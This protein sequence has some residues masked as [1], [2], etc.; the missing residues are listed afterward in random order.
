MNLTRCFG[1]IGTVLDNASLYL[2][3]FGVETSA[4]FVFSS[5]DLLAV[6]ARKAR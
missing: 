5:D 3:I 6:F 4:A 1:V 2:G